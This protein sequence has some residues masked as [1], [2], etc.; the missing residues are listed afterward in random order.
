MGVEITASG[1][2]ILTLKALSAYGILPRLEVAKIDGRFRAEVAQ[3][4]QR[5]VDS[6]F[7]ESASAVVDQC[8]DAAAHIASRWIW[9]HS[10][11]EEILRKDLAKVAETLAADPWKKFAASNVAKTIAILHSRGKS[12]EQFAK[13]LRTPTEEDTEFAVHAVGFLLR[14]LDL[15]LSPF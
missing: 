5:V 15:V 3:S 6:A 13:G 1:D 11:D 7:K 12:N 8:R 10:G 2:V 14:E 4:L 9:Q